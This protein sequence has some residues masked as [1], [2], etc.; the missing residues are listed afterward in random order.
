MVAIEAIKSV[1]GDCVQGRLEG[2]IRARQAR[3]PRGQPVAGGGGGGREA[4]LGGQ[5][6]SPH[7]SG[8]SGLKAVPTRA[9]LFAAAAPRYRLR[10]QTDSPNLISTDVRVPLDNKF[11]SSCPWVTGDAQQLLY[12]ACN[13]MPSD[14]R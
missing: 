12:S 2:D 4:E 8:D 13:L 6:S 9:R 14:R 1:R 7:L 11:M 10:Q 5:D 3:L